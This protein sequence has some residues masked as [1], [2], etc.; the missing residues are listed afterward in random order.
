[1]NMKLKWR[2]LL[3]V[4]VIVLVTTVVVWRGHD[5]ELQRLSPQEKEAMEYL[6]GYSFVLDGKRIEIKKKWTHKA[7][8]A[9]HDMLP[10]LEQMVPQL[11]SWNWT[12]DRP[13]ME[14]TETESTIVVTIPRWPPKPKVTYAWF[15]AD[16][17]SQVT[18]DK[19]T[20]MVISAWSG[21]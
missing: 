16:Y 3:S 20:G 8:L 7:F 4:L 14:I 9:Q 18:F 10:F 21:G 5:R 13:P 15:G 2:I 1:M 12:K 6:P 11:Q 17:C 19:E